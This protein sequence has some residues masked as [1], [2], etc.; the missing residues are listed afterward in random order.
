VV[1]AGV[2]AGTPVVDAGPA[3]AGAPPDAGPV[4]AADAGTPPP[5]KSGCGCMPGAASPDVFAG[6]LALAAL[7]LRRRR[8]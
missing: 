3:D 6:L 8:I 5:A 1:D 4:A 7:A 2:D